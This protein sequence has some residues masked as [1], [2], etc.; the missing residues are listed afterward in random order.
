MAEIS[1]VG[2]I[3]RTSD[4][5][6]GVKHEYRVLRGGD[7]IGTIIGEFIVGPDGKLS[8]EMLYYRK[9]GEPNNR[10]YFSKKAELANFMDQR[11]QKIEGG[12]IFA[13]LVVSGDNR[14]VYRTGIT[15]ARSQLFATEDRAIAFAKTGSSEIDSP[16]REK[17]GEKISG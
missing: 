1:V 2:P 14:L 6:H 7:E 16:Q 10:L 8:N 12:T 15:T 11:K 5:T 9:G 17:N 13:Y 4:V 3:E